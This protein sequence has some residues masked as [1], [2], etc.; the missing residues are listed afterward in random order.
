MVNSEQDA[1][2]SPAEDCPARAV[3]HLHELVSNLPY[4]AMMLLG[5]AVF[6]VAVGP[7]LTGWLLGGLY[8][9]YGVA[10]A[11]WIMIFVCPYCHFYGTQLCP[12]GYGQIAAKLRPAADASRFAEKFRRHIPV[13]VPLWV[14]PA[15][16]GVIALFGQ[17]SYALLVLLAAFVVNSFVILPLVST[18]HG[19]KRCPQ[20][21]TCPWMS[22]RRRKA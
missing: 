16:V 20:K 10:G 1:R 13:I 4:I 15:I 12:C 14:I 8:L 2:N 21:N 17:F 3:T 7:T 9:A 11:F 19:C 22:K 18:K 6:L 5:A